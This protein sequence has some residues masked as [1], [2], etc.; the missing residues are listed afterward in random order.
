MIYELR[1]TIAQKRL[2]VRQE[3]KII[4]RKSK[5]RKWLESKI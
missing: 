3:S 1:F 4:N 2:P 5:I